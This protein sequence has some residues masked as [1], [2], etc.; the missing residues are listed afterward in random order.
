MTSHQDD[1]TVGGR[2]VATL[3]WTGGDFPW[4]H[5][6]WEPGPDAGLLAPFLVDL[7]DG[8]RDLD[9]DALAE[10]GHASSTVLLG[11]DAFLHALLLT[12]GGGASWLVGTDPAPTGPDV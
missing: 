12:P 4:A 3:T 2:H 5:G 7:A 10:A 1:L 6:T 8:R 9:L 11:P